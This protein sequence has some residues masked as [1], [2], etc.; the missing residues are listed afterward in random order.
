STCRSPSCCSRP[1]RC[2]WPRS[3][4]TGRAMK[5][6]VTTRVGRQ[7]S[8]KTVNSEW[9]RV[10][11]NTSCEIHLPDPRVPLEQGMIVYRD[12]LV[13]MEGEAG[14]QVITRRSVRS[15]RMHDG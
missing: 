15:E 13:Y 2:T 3:S 11:R 6:L 10:G 12:G 7:Q 8:R 5:I 9:R 14:S 1:S 4:S